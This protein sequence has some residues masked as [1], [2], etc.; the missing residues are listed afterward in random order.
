MWVQRNKDSLHF[1]FTYIGPSANAQLDYIASTDADTELRHVERDGLQWG[2]ACISP[3]S[4]GLLDGMQIFLHLVAYEGLAAAKRAHLDNTDALC[5][6]LDPAHSL[7]TAL[8]ARVVRACAEDRGHRWTDMPVVL[9]S[10]GEI[11]DLP[12][13]TGETTRSWFTVSPATGHGVFDTLK[14]LVVATVNAY[15][16]GTLRP[17]VHAPDK[18]L[19]VEPSVL[20]VSP[21]DEQLAAAYEEARA[22]LERFIAKIESPGASH[23]HS[24][25]TRLADGEVFEHV[26]LIEPRWNGKEFVGKLDNVP[27][28][29]R[30]VRIGDTIRVAAGD[31]QDWMYIASD[32]IYGGYT[33]RVHAARGTPLPLPLADEPVAR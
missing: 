23:S 29:L 24:I 16:A 14:A 27:A 7:V 13:A 1:V 26:W 2:Y 15:R 3:L 21:H 5:I 30:N 10:L 4:L 11:G 33:I 6:V 12:E 31:V 20:K 18:S 28:D 8:H 9:Q 22:T 19:V 25:Q 32:K 17:F